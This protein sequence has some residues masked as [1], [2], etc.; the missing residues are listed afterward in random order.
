MKEFIKL[1]N[2]LNLCCGSKPGRIYVQAGPWPLF[3][4]VFQM[5]TEPPY[6]RAEAGYR[7]CFGPGPGDCK[8]GGN[9]GVHH[10]GFYHG[11][12]WQR[13]GPFIMLAGRGRFCPGRGPLLW[14]TWV[15]VP[16]RRRRIYLPVSYIWPAAGISFGLDILNRGIFSPHCRG[17]H[18]IF[19]L[20][21]GP[22]YRTVVYLNAVWGETSKPFALIPL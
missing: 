21:Y 16:Q 20:S 7:S 13:A 12:A 17:S 15:P 4:R 8:Y 11:R 22:G 3:Q 2:Y 14:R 9:R 5:S 6:Q 10:H 19:N 18:C 1:L